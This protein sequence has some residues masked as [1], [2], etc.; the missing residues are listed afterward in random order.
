MNG[1]RCRQAEALA[2]MGAPPDKVIVLDAPRAALTERAQRAG[3]CE[4]ELLARLDTWD[5]LHGCVL[6]AITLSRLTKVAEYH[7]WT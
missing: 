3:G 5:R 7:S 1:V 6:L 2:A 4:D